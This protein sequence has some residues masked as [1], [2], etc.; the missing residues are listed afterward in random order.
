MRNS[1]FW[2]TGF[3]TTSSATEAPESYRSGKWTSLSGF[4]AR[5]RL[6]DDLWL[7]LPHKNKANINSNIVWRK[8][9]FWKL[10]WE[11][12]TRTWKSWLGSQE[13]HSRSPVCARPACTQQKPQNEILA[14]ANIG[15][16]LKYEELAFYRMETTILHGC[17]NHIE[18]SCMKA[19]PERLSWGGG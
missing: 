8:Y 11:S 5:K 9:E 16:W 6:G 3:P 18:W 17:R 14:S 15:I 19:V 13:V 10:E 2:Q 1:K 12:W 4:S 7:R